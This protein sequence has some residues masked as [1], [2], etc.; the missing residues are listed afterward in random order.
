MHNSKTQISLEFLFAIGVVLFIFIF[1][2]IFTIEKRAEVSFAANYLEA[3]TDC[4]KLASLINAV[5]LTT[6][7]NITFKLNNNATISSGLI[8]VEKNSQTVSFCTFTAPLS[9]GSNTIKLTLG[10]V[11][12]RNVNNTVVVKNV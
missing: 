2:T 4:S 7:S 6:N 10:S 12:L 8:E 1:L 9:N 11:N 5:Y 3:K